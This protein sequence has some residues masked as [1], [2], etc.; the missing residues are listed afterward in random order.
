[1]KRILL[2]LTIAAGWLTPAATAQTP[3]Y[4]ADL[5]SSTDVGEVEKVPIGGGSFTTYATGFGLPVGL[6]M[7]SNGTLYI[8]DNNNGTILKVAPGGGTPTTYATGFSSP[9][10]LALDAAGF[11]YVADQGANQ[12]VK[13]AP[14]GLSHTVLA[15][16]I[17]P[18]G[19]ALNAAGTILYATD[20]SAQ[21]LYSMPTAAPSTPTPLAPVSFPTGVAV[22]SD[23]T[24]YVS[25]STT[26]SVRAV[27]LGG[28]SSTTYASGPS[29]NF[30]YGLAFDASGNLYIS[31]FGGGTIQRVAP[32]G[33]TPSTYVSGLNQPYFLAFAPVP[34]P[35]AVLFACAAMGGCVAGRRRVRNR[36]R[37]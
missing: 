28:G 17:S 13:V 9:L 25:S 3:L 32:G 24:I 34:E 15:T 18:I 8:S 4:V 29:I 2:A 33:G 27:P 10:A 12:V 36:L 30:P 19:L 22:G 31:T 35:G 7:A 23:G 14:G 16:S 6:A 11:L 26:N 1:M 37:G 21:E 5:N 20:N